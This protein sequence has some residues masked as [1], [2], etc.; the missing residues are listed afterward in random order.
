MRLGID[1]GGTKTAAIVVD[2]GGMVRSLHQ[3]ASGRGAD[4]VVA[5][6]TALAK[7]AMA[8]VAE[9]EPPL[10]R[11]VGACMPGLVDSASGHVRHAVNLGEERDVLVDGQVAVE[12]E[13][14]RQIP[15]L[16]G[17]GPDRAR[18]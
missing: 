18:A 7:R 3:G 8:E 10:R 17:D 11:T 6:A 13:T 1:I 4:G 9:F 14:L 12:A 15:D 16:V 5:V 2:S